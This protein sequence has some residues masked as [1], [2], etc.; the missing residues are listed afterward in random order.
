MADDERRISS[1]EARIA[2]LERR[3]D[4]QDKDISSLGSKLWT[5]VWVVLA[6]VANQILGLLPWGPK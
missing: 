3:A 2:V 1:L 4:D 6:F 5:G